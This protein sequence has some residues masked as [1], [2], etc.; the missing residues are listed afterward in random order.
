MNPDTSGYADAVRQDDLGNP[1]QYGY[2]GFWKRYAAACIDGSIIFF[3]SSLFFLTVQPTHSPLTWMAI[4]MVISWLY[5]A[6]F[7]SSSPQA[8]PG[9]M[10]VSIKVT[11]MNGNRIS[12]AQASGRHFSKIFSYLTS[13]IGYTFTQK[14]QGMHDIVASCLVVNKGVPTRAKTSIM[15]VASVIGTL[16]LGALLSAV[17]FPAK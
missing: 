10:T 2:A 13:L 4:I 11:D 1:P 16:F 3:L 7:E 15:V 12:F 6:L 5:F 9:K 17:L 8:T 14:K